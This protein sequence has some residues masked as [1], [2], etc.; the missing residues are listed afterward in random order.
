MGR[1]SDGF[2]IL[3]NSMLTVATG[4]TTGL[5]T[6]IFTPSLP[7]PAETGDADA[8]SDEINSSSEVDLSSEADSYDPPAWD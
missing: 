5:L 7:T 3:G 4:V 1:V 6:K 2:R 8:S